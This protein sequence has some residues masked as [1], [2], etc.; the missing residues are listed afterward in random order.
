MAKRYGRTLVSPRGADEYRLKAVF[1]GSDHA[2]MAGNCQRPVFVAMTGLQDGRIGRLHAMTEAFKI[3]PMID[4]APGIGWV[5]CYGQSAAA[6]ELQPLQPTHVDVAVRCR[7]C[8]K[9]LEA[10]AS[11]WRI[12]ALAE[13]KTAPR[14]WFGTLTGSPEYQFRLREL[15]RSAANQ[16]GD[17]F[18]LFED[19]KQFG[20]ICR[21]AAPDLTR[22]FKR[23]RKNSK[24]QLRYLL[25]TERHKSGDPHWHCLIHETESGPIRHRTLSQSWGLGFTQFKLVTDHRQAFYVCKYLAKSALSRVRAS[26]RYG[27]LQ[28][29]EDQLIERGNVIKF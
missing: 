16:D 15:A 29:Q 21:Q 19:A 1:R 18:D 14:T 25:V 2:D 4:W 5:D 3:D 7:Q 11:L 28:G 6:P 10:R 17:N 27:Q 20:S 8:S 24:V 12:R 9:C 23:L 26:S 22:Y 13:V